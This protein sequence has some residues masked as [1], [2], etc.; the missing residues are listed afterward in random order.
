MNRQAPRRYTSPMFVGIFWVTLGL[1]I[2]WMWL[3]PPYP[4]GWLLAGLT[5]LAAWVFSAWWFQTVPCPHCDNHGANKRGLCE[6]CQGF[7]ERVR[8]QVR[9]ARYLRRRRARSAQTQAPRG[10]SC[11]G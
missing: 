3:L 11:D 9:L 10:V 6:W 1:T 4:I 5:W 7:G 2:F 8:W